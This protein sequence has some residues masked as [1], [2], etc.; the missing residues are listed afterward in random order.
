MKCCENEPSCKYSAACQMQQDRS[1]LGIGRES[2]RSRRNNTGST[3]GEWQVPVSSRKEQVRCL[4]EGVQL[5]QGLRLCGAKGRPA[6]RH[7]HTCGSRGADTSPRIS[8]PGRASK[9]NHDRDCNRQGQADEL[10]PRV[11][12]LRCLFLGYLFV[13]VVVMAMTICHWVE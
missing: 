2:H 6:R 13:A 1:R 8:E 7:Q 9:C 11:W 12:L 5:R 4:I 10:W 3:G